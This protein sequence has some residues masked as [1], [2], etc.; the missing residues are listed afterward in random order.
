M[1]T[2]GE[3]AISPIGSESRTALYDFSSL[4]AANDTILSTNPAPQFEQQNNNPASGSIAFGTPAIV[5]SGTS[6]QVRASVVAGIVG[7]IYQTIC[8]VQT[9]GGDT[10]KCRGDYVLVSFG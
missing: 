7:T 2:L 9:A 8:T 5:S 6:V 10:L 3:I 1:P 4:L